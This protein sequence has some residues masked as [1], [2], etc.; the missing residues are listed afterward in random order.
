MKRSIQ[1]IALAAV[2]LL[3]GT[4]SVAS[5]NAAVKGRENDSDCLFFRSIHDWRALDSTHMI[6]WGPGS[7]TPYLVTLSFPLNDMRYAWRLAFI[8][9]NRDG[10][11]CSY[12]RD[13]V[14]VPDRFTSWRSS[15][16]GISKL[17]DEGIAALEAQYD[18][19]LRRDRGKAAT[20]G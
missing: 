5:T 11:L 10:T 12:G 8:D 20:A 18:V 19:K 4:A 13:A 17:D 6:V 7:R 9:G 16:R 14:V 15:I 2:L 1:T 3:A